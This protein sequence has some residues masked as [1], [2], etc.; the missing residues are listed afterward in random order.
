M[1]VNEDIIREMFKMAK[2]PY[3][4]NA[5]EVELLNAVVKLKEMNA[6]SQAEKGNETPK[7]MNTGMDFSSDD[8]EETLMSEDQ[9]DCILVVDDIGVV[10]YQLKVLLSNIGY[11]VYTAKDI[12]KA[13]NIFLKTKFDFVIMDLFVSTEQEGYSLLTETKKLITQHNLKTKIIVITA[14]N[15][16]ENKIKCLNGGADVFIKK[17]VGWQDKLVEIIENHKFGT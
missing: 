8:E 12:F 9:G 2:M 13:L 6:H 10:T 16:T 5:S 17:E 3:P 14:S 15:K 11:K 4:E 7:K 1:E